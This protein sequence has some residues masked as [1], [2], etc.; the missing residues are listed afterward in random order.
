MDD[1]Y[2]ILN[3]YP[4]CT[5]AEA[6]AAYRKAALMHHPDRHPPSRKAEA[7]RRFKLL[8]LAFQRICHDLG[9]PIEPS[10]ITPSS[11]KTVTKTGP[12][13]PSS[14]S[15]ALT[16]KSEKAASEKDNIDQK[17]SNKASLKK[18]AQD[19]KEE[20]AKNIQLDYLEEQ[21]PFDEQDLY[22]D[23]A[24]RSRHH[25][26]PII[27]ESEDHSIAES[28]ASQQPP[29]NRRSSVSR[30]GGSQSTGPRL[31]TSERD[32]NISP[33]YPHR[34]HQSHRQD[35]YDF[36]PSCRG[37]GTE[38]WD[39]GFGA[40]DFFSSHDRFGP[41]SSMMGSVGNGFDRMMSHA[42]EGL[43]MSGPDPSELSQMAGPNG[44][45]TMRMRQSKMVMGR[46]EDGSWAGKRME[47][48]MKM[49]DGRVEVAENAQ[50][51]KMGGSS[52]PRGRHPRH[53]NGHNDGE[54]WDP[55]P[56]Y[57][58]ARAHPGREQQYEPET[59]A[60]RRSHPP[61]DF[62]SADP[63]DLYGFGHSGGQ[64]APRMPHNSTGEPMPRRHGSASH[65]F[66]H[67]LGP[68]SGGYYEGDQVQRRPG[69]RNGYGG[70]GCRPSRSASI[71]SRAPI[72]PPGAHH[73]SMIRRSSGEVAT[74][75]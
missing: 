39:F 29:L 41:V 14:T 35:L 13:K 16:L 43:N 17:V 28:R 72:L 46:T 64:S 52:G 38:D 42:L 33:D 56:A 7:G 4:D 62:V 59:M 58:G 21:M 22:L 34:S 11:S 8:S 65:S 66:N 50:D 19:F 27:N 69:A 70:E 55:P 15:D 31:L 1:P 51:L 36:R 49:S 61:Q 48:Q 32:Q 68:A 18:Q 23:R 63:H 47:K 20:S 75:F 9:Y 24:S 12:N 67:P 45:C 57:N 30:I 60:H 44:N 74:R 71:S 26:Q 54:Y 73:H 25:G 37:G 6:K 40:D 3:V 2:S 53:G 10:D 5:Y